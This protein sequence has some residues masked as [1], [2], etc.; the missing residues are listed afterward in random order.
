MKNT[1]L[2]IASAALVFGASASPALAGS[3]DRAGAAVDRIKTSDLDLT[4]SSDQA[5]LEKRMERVVK[6][7]CSR[8]PYGQAVSRSEAKACQ[9]E[10]TQSLQRHFAAKADSARMGG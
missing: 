4:S 2:A 3:H 8:D 6:R 1:V 5:I 9:A 7:V 10:T